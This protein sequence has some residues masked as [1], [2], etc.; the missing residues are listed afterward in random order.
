V[1]CRG[2]VCV[3]TAS[4]FCWSTANKGGQDDRRWDC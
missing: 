3:T 2:G 4:L 1:A